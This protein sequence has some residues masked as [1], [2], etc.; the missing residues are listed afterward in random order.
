MI[1]LGFPAVK[2]IGQ[3][4]VALDKKLYYWT[5]SQW[6]DLGKMTL[7]GLEGDNPLL[8]IGEN[9]YLDENGKLCAKSQEQA[10]WTDYDPESPAYINNIPESLAYLRNITFELLQINGDVGTRGDQL[11]AGNHT[12]EN[13]TSTISGNW[14]PEGL[15]FAVPSGD[16]KKLYHTDGIINVHNWRSITEAYLPGIS[17]SKTNNLLTGVTIP[18]FS[19]IPPL[20]EILPE[21]K[22]IGETIRYQGA[23]KIKVPAKSF[24]S[25]LEFSSTVIKPRELVK[26]VLKDF[27]RML[28]YSGSYYTYLAWASDS[29]GT[30]FTL[31]YNPLLEFTAILTL[32]V[33]RSDLTTIDFEGLWVNYSSPSITYN[34]VAYASDLLGTDFTTVFNP[35]L[36]YIAIL[37]TN[38]EILAPI[39]ADFA[40]EWRNYGGKP[41]YTYRVFASDSSGTDFTDVYSKG[42]LYTSVI[43]SE[44]PLFLSVLNFTGS[45]ELVSEQSFFYV[46]Y[47]SGN[48]GED[49]LM[50]YNPLNT[51]I[52]VLH[53]KS[54]IATPVATDFEG[55]WINVNAPSVVYNYIAYASDMAGTDFSL[56]YNAV[57]PY[58][59][60]IKSRV[61]LSTPDVLNFEGLWERYRG[62]NFVYRGY[63]SDDIGT[64]FSMVY[65]PSL[66]YMAVFK[67]QVAEIELTVGVFEGLWKQ[68][69][70]VSD[71]TYFSYASDDT[72]TNFS[73]VAGGT[74]MAILNSPVSISPI[75]ENFYGL[76]DNPKAAHRYVNI[77]YALDEEGTGVYRKED[78]YSS[79]LFE[80]PLSEDYT[81]V[82]IKITEDPITDLL[83]E[84]F[85]G[86]W[87][88]KENAYIYTAYAFDC[89]GTA[90]TLDKNSSL[91][92]SIDEAS[93]TGGNTIDAETGEIW[94]DYDW[95]GITTVT[96][97]AYGRPEPKEFTHIIQSVEYGG[98]VVST[99]VLYNEMEEDPTQLHRTWEILRGEVVMDDEFLYYIYAKL[100]TE[101]GELYATIVVG[102]QYYREKIYHGYVN[103]LIGIVN[104]EEHNRVLALDWNNE[105]FVAGVKPKPVEVFETKWIPISQI[106]VLDLSSN[107]TGEQI[108][109]SKKQEYNKVTKVYEDTGEKNTRTITN[110]G[111]CPLPPPPPK[112]A[113]QSVGRGGVSTIPTT[114]I[115]P[116]VE[117]QTIPVTNTIASGT[118]KQYFSIPTGKYL[119]VRNRATLL[120]YRNIAAD[121]RLNGNR[122]WESSNIFSTVDATQFFITIDDK[123][124]G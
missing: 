98:E 45:W 28:P 12:H 65:N 116:Y 62:Y 30:G 119:H 61:V 104:S 109:V 75:A 57:L 70:G 114:P 71:N 121:S 43:T 53:S 87:K 99:A 100:P 69:R 122:I 113:F 38:T 86:L 52:A 44:I 55:L 96:V 115:T 82:A 103:I 24:N 25:V 4:H 73:M 32:I 51:F 90:F 58:L 3:T 41:A 74:H 94:F 78:P 68:F 77:V 124:Y 34:Y 39:A 67:T 85:T 18:E 46:A 93:I 36:K 110:L 112:Y 81:H 105:G 47:A 1:D 79:T 13:L 48:L 120:N 123:P 107:N 35:L 108:V 10:N 97:M 40:G 88:P 101:P 16:K 50:E 21:V 92:Y 7:S 63:A 29:T 91:R 106:C 8:E 2:R 76:W 31:Y 49:F 15:L 83:K 118:N 59:A 23:N 22:D 111:S 6:K 9:L 84:N 33:P 27:G 89:R 37:S 56:V 66:T 72:G 11:A 64:E 14:H 60:V 42:L 19:M 5:G 80:F 17:K 95:V 26:P 102:K 117:G 20:P 54:F